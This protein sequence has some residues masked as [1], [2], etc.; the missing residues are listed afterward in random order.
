MKIRILASNEVKHVENSLGSTLISA[1]LAEP[2]QDPVTD[3]PLPKPGD[4]KIPEPKWSV[5]VHPWS[6]PL[7]ETRSVL[8]IQMNFMHGSVQYCGHPKKVNAR[9]EWPGGGRYLNP[10]GRPVPPEIVAEYTKQW[11]AHEELRLTDA[12]L[13][14]T[15]V[16]DENRQRAKDKAEFDRAVAEGHV[17]RTRG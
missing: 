12:E 16:D 4:F 6:H 17:P 13:N 10:F 11:N 3:S 1:G 8:F 7:R 15:K 14:P 5:I 9:V 2:T